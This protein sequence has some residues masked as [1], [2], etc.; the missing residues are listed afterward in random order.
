MHSTCKWGFGDLKQ[1]S[2]GLQVSDLKSHKVDAVDVVLR[3]AEVT[4]KDDRRTDRRH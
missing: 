2:A 1:D 4:C 3:F